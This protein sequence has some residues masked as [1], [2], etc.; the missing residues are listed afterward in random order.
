VQAKGQRRKIITTGE[1]KAKVNLRKAIAADSKAELDRFKPD[2]E[3]YSAAY[4]NTAQTTALAIIEP[5]ITR[6]FDKREQRAAADLAK[7]HMSGER[8]QETTQTLRQLKSA[9]SGQVLVDLKRRQ[10]E[11]ATAMAGTQAMPAKA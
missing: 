1:E 8:L 5:M 3:R 2:A 9:L 7:A 6:A 4:C 11:L 10:I